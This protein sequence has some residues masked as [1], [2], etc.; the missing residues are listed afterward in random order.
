MHAIKTTGYSLDNSAHAAR[1]R[2][3]LT[4]E[5]NLSFP[6]SFPNRDAIPQ[7]R[8]VFVGTEV[9][10]F[11]QPRRIAGLTVMLRE[12]SCDRATPLLNFLL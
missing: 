8:D 4:E 12:R 7:L 11:S 10:Q 5:T 1:R 2:I 9:A 3:G 6:A